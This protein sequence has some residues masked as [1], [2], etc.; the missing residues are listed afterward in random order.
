MKRYLS[1]FPARELN[2][3]QDTIKKIIEICAIR[4]HRPDAPFLPPSSLVWSIGSCFAGEISV[5][6]KTRGVSTCTVHMEDHWISP[7]A[8][9]VVLEWIVEDKSLPQDFF[10]Q[11]VLRPEAKSEIQDALQKADLIIVTLGASLCWFDIS[12]RL[13]IFPAASKLNSK[14][15]IV[16]VGKNFH[17]RQTSVMENTSAI[18]RSIELIRQ[19]RSRP[20]V[21]T[22]S[23]V[24][25][26]ASIFDIPILSANTISKATLRLA[27]EEIRQKQLPDV[28]YWPSYEIVNWFG[29]HVERAFGEDDRDARHVRQAV[30]D[31]ISDAFLNSY[32][33]AG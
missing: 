21:F 8:L 9:Q 5:A 27:L 30:I 4:H 13:A 18:L 1:A 15:R 7:L 29:G 19:C 23:P 25:L 33:T 32:F 12:G 16:T 10:P 14:D 20:I 31:L 2:P 26:L 22:L 3:D 17:M 11:D 28:Y 24:P 6:L